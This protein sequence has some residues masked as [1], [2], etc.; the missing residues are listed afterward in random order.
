MSYKIYCS[1]QYII[2][3]LLT[4]KQD[5][6]PQRKPHREDHFLFGTSCFRLSTA[7]YMT[8]GRDSSFFHEQQ[9]Q[10]IIKQCKTYYIFL[11][12]EHE[13]LSWS[14]YCYLLIETAAPH[15]IACLAAL[16]SLRFSDLICN[17]LNKGPQRHIRSLFIANELRL[18]PL[19]RTR[20]FV[21]HT[22]SSNVL[23]LPARGAHANQDHDT[24][25]TRCDWVC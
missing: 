8:L 1:S 24:I 21:P 23:Q 20:L 3:S 19:S 10:Y 7:C 15:H 11:I 2:T 5:V 9:R 16:H 13:S 6:H 17:L 22:Q 25:P 12:K 14:L 18:G 4:K